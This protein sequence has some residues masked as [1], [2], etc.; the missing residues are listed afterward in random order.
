MITKNISKYLLTF[1]TAALMTLAVGGAV[2]AAPEGTPINNPTKYY[3]ISADGRYYLPEDFYINN[4]WIKLTI[5]KNKSVTLDLN[6]KTLKGGITVDE[7]ASLTLT[8]SAGGGMVDGF[9]SSS[10]GNIGVFVVRG[11][12]FIMENGIIC[13]HTSSGVFVD[14]TGS[15]TMN[16]GKISDNIGY[17]GGGVRVEF[18]DGI[19]RGT[20]T[21][22]GGLITGNTANVSSYS[23]GGGVFVDGYFYMNGGTI[24]GNTSYEGNGVF[25]S[26]TANTYIKGGTVTDNEGE[27]VY[28]ESVA[29][30][31]IRCYLQDS[32][33]IGTI[34]FEEDLY[35]KHGLISL[36]GPMTN[37]TPILIDNTE[38]DKFAEKS[39]NISLE[40]NIFS[41]KCKD[42]TKGIGL[43][44]D[45][46]TI[47]PAAPA[48]TLSSISPA[49]Q[50][51]EQGYG[52]TS[53]FTYDVSFAGNPDSHI[54]GYHWFSNT[55]PVNVGGTMIAGATGNTFTP[56]TGLAPG[57]YYYY[58]AVDSKNDNTNSYR[59]DASSVVTFKVSAPPAPPEPE[60]EPEPAVVY[61]D[62]KRVYVTARKVTLNAGKTKKLKAVV[63]PTKAVNRQ[64]TW[65]STNPEVAEVSSNG[66]VTAK[67]AG[68]ATIIATSMDPSKKS[69]CTVT[70]K[71]P[72]AVK[73]VGLSTTKTTMKSGKTK[74]LKANVRP[75][76]AAN[77]AVSWETSDKTVVSFEVINSQKIKLTAHNPGTATITVTTADGGKT[78]KCK[79]T[80]K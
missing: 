57:T 60:P 70:V 67:K 25:V 47:R 31:G 30:P 7:G 16:G 2:Y 21:M 56:P 69:S 44:E 58:C 80:V 48:P 75:A 51:A 32:P 22:N 71:G 41:F 77:K 43:D 53:S 28:L 73:S 35:S 5:N 6:G 55:T 20:F 13:N 1:I 33:N 23:E 64:V 27:D 4:D 78:K 36:S 38:G 66:V 19:G 3:S 17:Y 45:S 50:S 54:L 65:T 76:K 9:N 46:L 14:P 34:K 72:V 29:T 49:D 24:T 59:R 79:V 63:L 39:N 62:I 74:I 11:A 37:T 40:E 52:S 68:K 15:F 61:K 10:A 26:N 12:E 18:Q 42:D 8:D